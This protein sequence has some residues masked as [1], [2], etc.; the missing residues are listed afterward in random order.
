[1]T[2]HRE[3]Y[4]SLEKTCQEWNRMYDEKA[5]RVRELEVELAAEKASHAITAAL[6]TFGYQ[7]ETKGEQG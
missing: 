5:A 3:N 1:M 7:K 2:S 4:E 6:A